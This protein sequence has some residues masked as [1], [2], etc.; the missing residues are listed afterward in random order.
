MWASE[1]DTP[2]FSITSFASNHWLLTSYLPWGPTEHR[3]HSEVPGVQHL[4]GF[5]LCQTVLQQVLCTRPGLLHPYPQCRGP[6]CKLLVLLSSPA[7]HSNLQWSHFT[8]KGTRRHLCCSTAISRWR[9]QKD[10]VNWKRFEI[11]LVLVPY[12]GYASSVHIS[13]FTSV[14]DRR[15]Y[16]QCT[17]GML[18]SLDAALLIPFV[19][20]FHCHISIKKAVEKAIVS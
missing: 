2:C 4:A 12:L 3:P 14:L 8:E 17:P 18:H 9:R 16:G 19:A 1:L 10:G 20:G 7:T 11:E 6:C 5:R 13:S 15:G